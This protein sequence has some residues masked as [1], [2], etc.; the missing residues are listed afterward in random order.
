VAATN[1]PTGDDLAF[2]GVIAQAELIRTGAITARA[3]VE[4]CLERI[5]RLDGELNA[6][7]VVLAERALAEADQAD[8]RRQAGDDRPL[9]GVP[10][11]VKDDMDV[12]GEVTTKGSIAH[13]APATQDA[14]IVRRLRE[15]GAVIV[16]KTNV[17][18]LMTM[19]FS[20][21]VWYGAT[22]NP[23]D[24]DRT[25]GGSSGG[26]AAAVAAGLVAAAT[27][28]DGAGSIRI[29]AACCGLVGLKPQRGR[30]PTP[31]P[32]WK[33]M[34]TYGF[35]ARTVADAA[36]LYDL[37][38]DGGESFADAAAREPGRLRVA[39][40]VKPMIGTRSKPDA[41]VLGAIEQA[42]RLLR[43]AGHEV[44]AREL[45]YG[46]AS[47]SIT[48]RYLAGIAEDA[49]RLPRRERLD[50]RSRGLVRMGSAIPPAFVRRAVAAAETDA[51]RIGA[52]FDHADVVLL[53]AY[54]RLPLRIGEMEG[55]AG[56]ASLDRAVN[57][58][59]FEGLFNHTG[60]PALAIP[61]AYT[62]SG[63]PIAVQ[64]AAPPD[65]EAVLLSLAAQLESIVGWPERRPPFATGGTRE[66]R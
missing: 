61:V 15:A 22:R 10:I 45:D 8:A 21:T 33:G 20:E 42:R 57:F 16:G 50:R 36:L 64:L 24:L 52:I 37:V 6:F 51:R 7:R 55:L 41:T 39:V 40:S 28:S 13:G 38:K 34:S 4:R 54:T 3:L 26:S 63:F 66:P 47:A 19:P 65:G 29:P 9:L 5:A 32:D 11:A 27:G 46:A 59:P 23:W 1:A 53:P 35:E 18:E 25:P 17:P 44:T 14:E 30:V 48:T 49:A 58:V 31:Q 43:E 56:A 62:E 12:A 2:A 60:Q